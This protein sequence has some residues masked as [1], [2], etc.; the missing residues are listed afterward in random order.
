[1]LQILFKCGGVASSAS[2]TV[3]GAA[4]GTGWLLFNQNLKQFLQQNLE[5]GL[6]SLNP[7]FKVW[8]FP[9]EHLTQEEIAAIHLYTQ[10]GPF[11]KDLS[12]KLRAEDR[13][14]LRPYLFYLKLL[15]TA[16]YKLPTINTQVYRGVDV[17]FS[18]LEDCAKGCEVI[19]WALSS[20]SLEVEV[21]QSV[22]PSNGGRTIFK[23]L[24][25]NGVNIRR[26]SAIKRESEVIL[27]PGTEL[28]VES[29]L[30]PAEGLTIVQMKQTDSPSFLDFSRG[31]VQVGTIAGR[32]FCLFGLDS[33]PGL[34]CSFQ[35]AKHG[36]KV[37][38][39][40]GPAPVAE[41]HDGSPGEHRFVDEGPPQCL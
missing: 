14:E 3:A 8:R 1:M 6:P 24:C 2:K 5:E 36:R 37:I 30:S 39:R 31:D 26:Y 22:L 11:Y 4:S 38:Q 41:G 15:L 12:A 10:A 34:I 27:L 19:W 28:R 35:T 29:I 25:R 20:C 18:E 17:C 13:E 16:R 32:G 23:V 21:L 33:D 7:K 40:L 9:D